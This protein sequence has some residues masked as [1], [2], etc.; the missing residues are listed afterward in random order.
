M[1]K[2]ENGDELWSDGPNKK[3]HEDID[4]SWAKKKGDTFYGYKIHVKVDAKSKIIEIHYASDTSVHDSQAM[5]LLL[6]EKD[7]DQTLHA[8]SAYIGPNQ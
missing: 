4:A 6:T 8:D 5:E 1:I 2:E 3:R 7:K